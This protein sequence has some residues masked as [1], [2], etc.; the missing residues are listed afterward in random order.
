MIVPTLTVPLYAR[1]SC[2]A[3]GSLSTF[4]GLVI[5]ADTPRP[6]RRALSAGMTRAT[7]AQASAYAFAGA[8]VAVPGPAPLLIVGARS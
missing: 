4:P 3:A 1:R 8:D 6:T 2:G 5:P 7:V